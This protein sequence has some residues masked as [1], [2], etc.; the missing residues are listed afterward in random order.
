MLPIL[1][2][3]RLPAFAAAL[4]LIL[5]PLF[6]E[7]LLLACRENELRAAVFACQRFVFHGEASELY[8]R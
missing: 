7:K 8:E 2:A 1:R 4:R 5:E 6:S 3:A